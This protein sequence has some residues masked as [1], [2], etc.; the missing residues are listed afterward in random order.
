[1]YST[2]HKYICVLLTPVCA[3]NYYLPGLPRSHIIDMKNLHFV[4]KSEKI[5]RYGMT[6]SSNNLGVTY[7]FQPKLKTAVRFTYYSC[8]IFFFLN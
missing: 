5:K 4:F 6:R 7:R 2:V 1:M 8:L 3:I